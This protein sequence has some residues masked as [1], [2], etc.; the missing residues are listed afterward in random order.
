MPAELVKHIFLRHRT[1]EA[2]QKFSSENPSIAGGA[3]LRGLAAK[4]LVEGI[5]RVLTSK[6]ETSELKDYLDSCI[7]ELNFILGFGYS[8]SM[9]FHQKTTKT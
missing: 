2:L 6:P 7:G 1:D 8:V 9:L 4:R 3:D 5:E